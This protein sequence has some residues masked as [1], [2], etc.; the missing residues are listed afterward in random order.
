MV[1]AQAP[2]LK[3]VSQF[4]PIFGIFMIDLKTGDIIKRP[5]GILIIPSISEKE[6]NS[7]IFKK[8]RIA[9]HRYQVNYVRYRDILYGFSTLDSAGNQFH[10]RIGFSANNKGNWRY[11][12]R[13]VYFINLQIA[14]K[15][16]DFYERLEK[17]KKWHDKWMK[18]SIGVSPVANY[19]WGTLESSLNLK[20]EEA[21][22]GLRYSNDALERTG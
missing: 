2:Q 15:Y 8:D 11:S 19:W 4:N 13:S 3:A 7:L 20:A 1:R 10:A 21:L 16:D 5:E 18:K 14:E 22:I 12:I 17:T 9:D 6:F